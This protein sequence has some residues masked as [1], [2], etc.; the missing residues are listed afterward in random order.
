MRRR[1]M[2]FDR[3]CSNDLERLSWPHNSHNLRD[4]HFYTASERATFGAVIIAPGI[5]EAKARKKERKHPVNYELSALKK[6]EPCTI[7]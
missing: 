2:K 3:N 5:N 4:Q 7:S 1:P 6:L